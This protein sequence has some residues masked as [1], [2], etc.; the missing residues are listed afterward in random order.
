MPHGPKVASIQQPPLEVYSRLAA[1]VKILLCRVLGAE[2]ADLFFAKARERTRHDYPCI[3]TIDLPRLLAGE[4]RAQ[5]ESVEGR[6]HLCQ[7]L[8]VLTESVFE[9]VRR[10][11]GNV[12]GAALWETV[13]E[14]VGPHTCVLDE[15]EWPF[16][17]TAE[18]QGAISTGTGRAGFVHRATRRE[19]RGAAERD[20]PPGQGSRRQ[21]HGSFTPF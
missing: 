10:A 4:R 15:L 17:E 21:A 8:R 7:G 14:A 19:R 3:E 9:D 11:T 1:R 20:A 16:H 5:S 18:R 6:Q 12:L 2:V 13:H